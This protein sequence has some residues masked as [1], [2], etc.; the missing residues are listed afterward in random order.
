MK[1]SLER[2]KHLWPFFVWNAAASYMNFWKLT[3]YTLKL[4]SICPE[5]Y[6]IPTHDYHTG[7]KVL[8]FSERI[9]F[10]SLKDLI[11]TFINRF[12]K[13]TEEKYPFLKYDGIYYFLFAGVLNTEGENRGIELLEEYKEEIAHLKQIAYYRNIHNLLIKFIS[14]IK[15]KGFKPKQLFFAI[16]RFHRWHL[17]NGNAQYDAQAEMLG[18][19]YN[20]YH[21]PELGK[22]L[23]SDKN[24]FFP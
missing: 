9:E 14:H 8:S 3:G 22:Q 6:I 15:E 19:L 20:M 24:P 11:D 1:N 18:D 23:Q 2:T 17:L 16:K 21:L 10:S 5:N 12:I 13:D 7:T 4:A